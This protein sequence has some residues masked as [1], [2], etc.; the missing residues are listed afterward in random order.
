MI[1]VQMQKSIDYRILQRVMLMKRLKRLK[2]TTQIDGIYDKIQE[3]KNE[4]F[5][6]EQEI[7]GFE[8]EVENIK[9][10]A[11]VIYGEDE[12]VKYLDNAI[13]WS[14]LHL[15]LFDPLAVLLLITSAGLI[16]N[17][18]TIGKYKNRQ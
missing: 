4:R 5:V 12:S 9:Y 6:F 14:F 8:R 3:Y 16:A 17:S 15:S 18:P 2:N 10:V 7:L 1:V 11:E 13:R